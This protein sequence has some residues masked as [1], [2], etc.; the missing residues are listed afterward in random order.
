M[1]PNVGGTGPRKKIKKV[2][3]GARDFSLKEKSN[4]TWSLF[5]FSLG[6]V[7]HLRFIQLEEYP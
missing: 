7:I 5:G 6:Y 4:Q 3:C 2:L 1:L